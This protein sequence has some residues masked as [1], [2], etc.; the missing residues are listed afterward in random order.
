MYNQTNLIVANGN[1]PQNDRVSAAIAPEDSG[2]PLHDG[3]SAHYGFLCGILVN[4][5][6]QHITNVRQN[7]KM[8]VNTLYWNLGLP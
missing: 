8:S 7:V 3:E 6:I 1:T 2:A 4:K 5:K